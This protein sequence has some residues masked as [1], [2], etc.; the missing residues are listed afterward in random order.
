MGSTMG[1][2]IFICEVSDL[3]ENI[4]LSGGQGG[5]AKT[6]QSVFSSSGRSP[7]IASLHSAPKTPSAFCRTWVRSPHPVGI[8]RSADARSRMADR[9]GFEPTRRFPVHTLSKRAPSATRPPVL[10]KRRDYSVSLFS[11]KRGVRHP[12][13]RIRASQDWRAR[14]PR[15]RPHRCGISTSILGCVPFFSRKIR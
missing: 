4:S 2:I 3:I 5:I 14:S 1:R 8:L 6:R 15:A 10:T 12:A 9:V 11:G 7:R 13:S